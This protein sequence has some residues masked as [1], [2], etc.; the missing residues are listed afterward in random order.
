MRW[1]P[2]SRDRGRNTPRRAG[3]NFGLGN[4]SFEGDVDC[5]ADGWFATG[6][7]GGANARETRILLTLGYDVERLRRTELRAIPIRSIPTGELLSAIAIMSYE[8]CRFIRMNLNDNWQ[9]T[10]DK[11]ETKGEQKCS[12]PKRLFSNTIPSF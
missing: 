11:W 8:K 6:T 1:Y 2:L 5:S 7:Q 9:R 12:N 4:G 3:R 10:N